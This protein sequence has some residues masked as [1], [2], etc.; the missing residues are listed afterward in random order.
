LDLDADGEFVY[1]PNT[2]FCGTDEFTYRVCNNGTTC[3]ATATVSIDL[4]DTQQPLLQNIPEDINISCDDELPLPPIVDAW[5]NCHSV[6][7]GL[8][9]ASNQGE[10]DSCSIYSYSIFRTWSASDYCGNSTAEQ[11]VVNIQD[12]TAPDIYRIYNLPN[13]G[14]MVAGVMENVSHRW[15]NITLPIDFAT[16]PVVLAQV[17]TR[18]DVTTVVPRLKNI[19]PSHFQMRLQEE[20]NEDDIHDVESV[21][22]IA[23]EEGVSTDGL[24]FEV[25][26]KLASSNTSTLSF[27][28]P[29]S[30]PGL[31]GTI[32]TNNENNPVAFR[33]D[34]LNS[35]S[36][37][38]Y[39]Q[40]EESLDPETNHGFEIF[41]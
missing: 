6:T 21:A 4:T 11:Q 7:L 16:T 18:N 14:R 39:L 41:F 34:N 13:G 24:P 5:E 25:G 22:W 29:Y 32:Q 33:Y 19:A 23:F 30:N 1:T 26:T 40:E 3:C 27:S 17:V 36:A 12:I 37:S 15:K 35:T 2:S 28:Q 20:E 31:I 8:D 10:L 9:E 38:I